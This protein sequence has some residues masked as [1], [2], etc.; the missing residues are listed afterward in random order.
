MYDD[1]G[2]C[3][4][5][6]PRFQLWAQASCSPHTWVSEPSWA[7]RHSSSTANFTLHFLPLSPGTTSELQEGLNLSFSWQ[8][9]NMVPLTAASPV[10]SS[11]CH[12][13]LQ[14]WLHFHGVQGPGRHEPPTRGTQVTLPLESPREGK[15]SSPSAGDHENCHGTSTIS[16]KEALPLVFCIL[17][18]LGHGCRWRAGGPTNM[19]ASE[20]CF[21][22][23]GCRHGCSWPLE[24]HGNWCR[25]NPTSNS[26][27]TELSSNSPPPV[28]AKRKYNYRLLI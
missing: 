22:T 2:L 21:P 10:C 28:I 19:T 5:R 11:V 12:P 7:F 20:V 9:V 18:L 24:P 8:I 6:Q 13:Q 26:W 27:H 14:P 16:S 15:A 3:S 25:K 4:S 17:T 23:L 1:C